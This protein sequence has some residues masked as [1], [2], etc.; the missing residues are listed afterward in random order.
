[1]A[2]LTGSSVLLGQI[3]VQSRRSTLDLRALSN[4]RDEE[5]RGCNEGGEGKGSWLT[6]VLWALA[7]VAVVT[8]VV[9]GAVHLLASLMRRHGSLSMHAAVVTVVPIH[10]RRRG[11]LSTLAAV[12]SWPTTHL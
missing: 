4:Y 2:L 1:M 6:W 3:W 5:R 8:T 10:V 11:S 7:L 12:A 9:V